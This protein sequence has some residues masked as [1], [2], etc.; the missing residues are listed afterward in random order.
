MKTKQE[1]K[2]TKEHLKKSRDGRSSGMFYDGSAGRYVQ[3]VF[4]ALCVIAVGVGYLGNQVSFLPWTHF[5]L[6]F[7]GWGALFLIVPAIYS[8][9]RKPFSLFWYI[10]LLIGTM[11]LAS[12]WI[13]F[14]KNWFSIA[15]AVLIIIIGLRILLNPII[16]RARHRKFKKSMT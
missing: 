5:T 12:N 9:L 4:L 1:M 15:V 2:N 3:K 11:I 10:C 16:R 6:F 8:L 13:S 7:P 14:P